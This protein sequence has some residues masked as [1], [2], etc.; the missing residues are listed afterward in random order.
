MVIVIF[1]YDIHLITNKDV[2][3]IINFYIYNSV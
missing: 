1:I 3:S 2:Y